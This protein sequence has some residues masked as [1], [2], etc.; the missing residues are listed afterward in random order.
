MFAGGATQVVSV[1]VAVLPVPPLVDVTCTELRPPVVAVTSTEN[2][3]EPPGA[4]VP[5]ASVTVPEPPT[6]VTELPA[7][8]WLAAGETFGTAATVIPA[9]ANAS[10]NATPVR[11]TVFAAGLVIINVKVELPPGVVFAGVNALAITGGATTVNVAV[12]L[13]VPATGVCVEVTPEVVFG[14]LPGVLLVT[15]NI[16]VQEPV[17]GIEIPVKLRAVA[18]ALNVFGV[19]ATQV[20]VTAPPT[21][22][23][24]TSVS[25]NAA[26]VSWLAFELLSVIATLVLPPIGIDAAPNTLAIVGDASTVKL[27]V[28]V[29]PVPSS[30]V[31]SW[32]ELFLTPAV[33]PVTLTLKVQFVLVAKAAP[34]SA[35][36][37]D[38]SIA[39][40]V[41]L[42]Q[43]PVTPFGVATTSPAGSVSVKPTPESEEVA[44]L[45]VIV[46]DSDVE[47]PT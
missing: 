32:T 37:P 10:V 24:F 25:V 41:P 29:A 3:H 45:L 17:A 12:L 36:E 46:N 22:L 23:I 5:D 38:P 14:L 18:P 44:L 27:A 33:V 19:V 15:P 39:V 13:T 11:P 31:E 35:I 6:A 42:G 30:V 16:T 1:A 2:V 9:G 34:D 21:A 40:I 28:A 7:P 8:H 4:I 47:P 43:L 20:P 26:P